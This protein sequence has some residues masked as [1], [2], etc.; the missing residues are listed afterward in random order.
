MFTE[1]LLIIISRFLCLSFFFF[2]M[3]YSNRYSC[4]NILIK[5]C[6]Y[7]QGKN[8]ST[9]TRI[10]LFW[11]VENFLI[12]ARSFFLWIM[13][14]HEI[15]RSMDIFIHRLFGWPNYFDFFSKNGRNPWIFSSWSTLYFLSMDF[16]ISGHNSSLHKP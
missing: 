2:D 3:V 15:D 5:K 13:D 9:S 1:N 11:E 8:K 4:W 14:F 12:R 7:R 10:I 16:R 6:I